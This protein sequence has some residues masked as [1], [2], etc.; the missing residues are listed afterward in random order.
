MKLQI[1]ANP[2]SS[3]NYYTEFYL[4]E[5]KTKPVLLCIIWNTANFQAWLQQFDKFSLTFETFKIFKLL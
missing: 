3:E 4:Y 2:K 5:E 1:A